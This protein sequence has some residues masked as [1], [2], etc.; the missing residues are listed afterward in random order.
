MNKKL[1][2]TFVV[3]CVILAFLC[4]EISIMTNLHQNIKV[5]TET[6][7]NDKNYE[8]NLRIFLSIIAILFSV[9]SSLACFKIAKKRN[10]DSLKW[11]KYGFFFNIWALI[12][13]LFFSEEKESKN[14]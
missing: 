8:I 5:I 3:L 10:I 1:I 13:L 12:Y 11:A 6:A 14:A 2:I 9:L 7:N 4:F